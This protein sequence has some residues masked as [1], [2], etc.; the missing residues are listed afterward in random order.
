MILHNDWLPPSLLLAVLQVLGIQ[1]VGSTGAVRLG[2]ELLVHW[3][4]IRSAWCG[5]VYLPT[6][7]DGK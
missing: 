7:C 1:T 6:P 4:D 2:A 5:P 3:Y